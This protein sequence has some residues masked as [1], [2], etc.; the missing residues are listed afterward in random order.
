MSLFDRF[1]FRVGIFIY[2]VFNYDRICMHFNWFTYQHHVPSKQLIV[3]I[4]VRFSFSTDKNGIQE[5][6]QIRI[7]SLRSLAGWFNPII[8]G[9]G[10]PHFL[11]D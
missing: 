3:T 4:K 9:G 10:D 1:S 6:I 8:H 11:H 5:E 7:E 2:T